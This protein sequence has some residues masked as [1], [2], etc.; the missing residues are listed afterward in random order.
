MSRKRGGS[1][2][3]KA[4]D[5]EAEFGD[6]G[7]E[8]NRIAYISALVLNSSIPPLDARDRWLEVSLFQIERAT[9]RK[10][11]STFSKMAKAHCERAAI[12]AERFERRYLPK[13]DFKGRKA[14]L[15][16]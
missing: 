8:E 10:V 2:L 9:M 6:L 14:A 15:E 13:G 3:H 12:L 11:V 5:I 16:R 1:A 7:V 4:Y